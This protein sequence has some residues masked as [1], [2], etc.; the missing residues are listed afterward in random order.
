[1]Q[2]VQPSVLGMLET[3]F[4]GIVR[5]PILFFQILSRVRDLLESEP[6]VDVDAKILKDNQPNIR[7]K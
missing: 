1:M 4:V 5:A 2:Q 7:E 3:I 6:L